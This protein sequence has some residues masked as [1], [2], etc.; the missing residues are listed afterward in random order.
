MPSKK[1]MG[2][3]AFVDVLMLVAGII[4]LVLSLV[5]GSHDTLRNMVINSQDRTVGLALGIILIV[6]WVYSIFAIIQPNHVTVWIVALNY[7]LL[8]DS[9]VVV[10]IGSVI[11]FF[12]LRERND[13]FHAFAAQSNASQILIQDE[14]K[15]CGYF[16]S[17]DIVT[18]GGNFCANQT[19]VET[20]NNATGNFCVGPITSFADNA[21]NNIFS[22][23]FGWVAITLSLLLLS[24]CVVNKRKESERFRKID[25]KR[26]GRGFA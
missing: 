6:T 25:E 2:C 17:S 13:F 7:L 20:T 9:V 23:I 14:L 4:T 22:T 5:W 12:T 1:L 10:S 11:W 18:I 15:C 3:W 24:I 21:L 16:T 8:I 26:G 19:F